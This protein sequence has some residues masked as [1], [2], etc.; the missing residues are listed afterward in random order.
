M[1]NI[2]TSKSVN[3]P[4]C[5]GKV[6]NFCGSIDTTDFPSGGDMVIECT[7]GSKYD[8]QH[9]HFWVCDECIEKLFYGKEN[10]GNIVK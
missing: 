3:T 7:Y 2:M 10:Q 1:T 6:C 8:E 5:V 9:F 4:I